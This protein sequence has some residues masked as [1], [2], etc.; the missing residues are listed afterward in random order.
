MLTSNNNRAFLFV[1]ISANQKKD[2][3]SNFT[4]LI[5][6]FDLANQKIGTYFWLAETFKTKTI[7]EKLQ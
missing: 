6:Q 1:K 2:T 3:E 5:S 4:I 7:D